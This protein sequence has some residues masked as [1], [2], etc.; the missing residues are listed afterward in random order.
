M[1]ASG[2]E[3]QRETRTAAT[4][5]AQR[6]R[7]ERRDRMPPRIERGQTLGIVAPAG[8][9]KLERLHARA[10]AARRC[11]PAAHRADSVPAPRARRACRAISPPP[12]T[13]APPS[14]TRCSRDPRRPR[15]PARARRLRPHADPA[16]ARCRS[17]ARAIPSRS[18]GSPMRPRCSR[19]RTRAGVRGIHGPM[20]VQLASLADSDI[21][22]LIAMLTE[23]AR[24]GRAAVAARG[25]RHAAVSRSARRRQPDDVRR[26][27]SAR[28]G[29]CRCAARSR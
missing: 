1:A 23:R 5:V 14:S 25:A 12:T 10:R 16:A 7:H 13:C 18:S 8:P 26:C 24:A 22:H 19:G 6:Q 15:D 4:Q 11:V 3:R 17:A 9:V 20:V 28:R 21:A 29:R 27:S 2:D